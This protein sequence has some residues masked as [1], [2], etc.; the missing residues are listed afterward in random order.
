MY[1]YDLILFFGLVINLMVPLLLIVGIVDTIRMGVPVFRK[2]EVSFKEKLLSILKRFAVWFVIVLTVFFCKM[3]YSHFFNLN[4]PVDKPVIYLYPEKTTDVTVQLDYQGE[5]IADYPEYDTAIGGWHVTAHTGGTLFNNADGKEYSYLFWEGEPNTSTNWDFSKGFVIKGEDTREFL[6]DILPKMGL[7][8]KEYNEFIVYWYPKMKDNT[9]NLIHFAGSEYTD[10]ASL[11]ITPQPDSLL[12]VF[13]VYKSLE[14]P[15][16][17]EPQ[18]IAPFE[19]N[20]F[21]VVEW[22]GTEL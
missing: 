10:T 18:E 17:I 1:T 13:M 4:R 6:Q 21:T 12:R 22:G 11:T 3:A 8:P 5:L 16:S 7:T 19:R 14:E 9:Y 20:G 15:T 2:K